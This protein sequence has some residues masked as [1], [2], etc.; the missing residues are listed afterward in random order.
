MCYQEGEN[1]HLI[2]DFS[3]NLFIFIFWIR[4]FLL[5]LIFGNHLHRRYHFIKNIKSNQYFFLVK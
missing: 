3:A 1:L 4:Y 5:C 2:A